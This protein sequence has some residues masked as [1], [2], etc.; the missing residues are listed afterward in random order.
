VKPAGTVDDLLR[1][2]ASL[3]GRASARL[4][5]DWVELGL[6]D[7]PQRRSEGRG[8]GSTKALYSPPQ[9]RLFFE[10]MKLRQRGATIGVLCNPP[11]WLWLDWGDA[12]V[13]LRQARR[14]LTTWARK[15]GKA[16]WGRARRTAS[17]VVTQF[18]H[19]DAAPSDRA[20][21]VDTIAKAA[22]S[23]TTDMAALE[24][25]LNDVFDPYKIGRT[26]GPGRLTASDYIRLVEVR[27]AGLAGIGEASDETYLQARLMYRQSWTQYLLAERP[28]LERATG[29]DDL[30]IFKEVPTNERALRACSD[31]MTHLGLLTWT[32]AHRTPDEEE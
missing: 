32:A 29:P 12:Y 10:L 22:Y 26:I 28:I 9:R 7:H 19:P 4:I 6:L 17:D 1:D 31:L 2:V 11:V 20:K 21:L 5:A 27:T 8:R 25:R 16:P 23:G 18:A 13:P 14:A 3:G 24:T 15:Y 30:N